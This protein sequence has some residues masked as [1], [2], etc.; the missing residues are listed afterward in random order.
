MKL[1]DRV[2]GTRKAPPSLLS[3]T[4]IFANL[5]RELSG[6]AEKDRRP[7]RDIA[8][9]LAA[10]VSLTQSEKDVL[11][12]AIARGTITEE[13]MAGWVGTILA[14]E[15]QLQA[16]VEGVCLANAAKA[17]AT[18]AHE[19]IKKLEAELAEAK[20][21]SIDEHYK[22]LAASQGIANLVS[23]ARDH[24][25]LFGDVDVRELIERHVKLAEQQG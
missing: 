5:K 22:S 10:E 3:A 19:R 16:T 20:A 11:S 23:E 18:G 25:D 7:L 4:G 24:A 2:V 1:I 13:K 15:K 12:S 21:R 8:R 9:K 6:Q 17:V 14:F